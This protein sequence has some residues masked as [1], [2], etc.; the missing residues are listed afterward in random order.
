M[1]KKLKLSECPSCGSD[2]IGIRTDKRGVAEYY[3]EDCGKG[4]GKASS[5]DLVGIIDLLISD[6]EPRKQ[7]VERPKMPCKYCTE[8]YVMLQGTLQTRVIQVPIEPVYCPMCGRKLSEHDK[9][10]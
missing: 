1:N 4:L 3:C 2:N 5:A 7:S 6:N 8:R 10:Y 9:D